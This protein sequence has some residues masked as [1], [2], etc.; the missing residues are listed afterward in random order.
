MLAGEGEGRIY[1]SKMEILEY[2]E[3]VQ[4]KDPVGSED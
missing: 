4:G 1:F 2:Y 3:Q